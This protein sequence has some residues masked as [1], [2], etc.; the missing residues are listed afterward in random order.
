L[1]EPLKENFFIT[2]FKNTSYIKLSKTFHQSKK[3]LEALLLLMG[4]WACR[5]VNTSSPQPFKHSRKVDCIKLLVK[6]P[7][8]FSCFIFICTCRTFIA[9]YM[10]M[11]NTRK[12]MRSDR[13]RSASFAPRW[14]KH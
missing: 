7:Q 13:D 6:A 8:P 10:Y 4:G 1:H 5:E 14:P 2:K 3:I 12:T 9:R 11:W